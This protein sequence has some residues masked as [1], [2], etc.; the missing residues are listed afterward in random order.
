MSKGAAV[1]TVVARFHHP[2]RDIDQIESDLVRAGARDARVTG[3]TVALDFGEASEESAVEAARHA[4]DQI[5]ATR[6]KVRYPKRSRPQQLDGAGSAIAESDGLTDARAKAE[7][8]NL[9]AR[10]EMGVF[11]HP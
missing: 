11:G 10:I 1:N 6:I 9:M 8:A 2:S 5:G 7:A 3:Y 4:L